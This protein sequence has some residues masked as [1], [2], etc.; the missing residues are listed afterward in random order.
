MSV[1]K[2]PYAFKVGSKIMMK[3]HA[4]Q[5]YPVKKRKEMSDYMSKS[6]IRFP[7]NSSFSKTSNNEKICKI[8]ANIY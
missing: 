5:Y 1:T 3:E 4:P 2:N 8:I 6:S 7:L